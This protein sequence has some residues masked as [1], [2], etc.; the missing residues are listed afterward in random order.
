MCE[1]IYAM[2]LNITNSKV[3]GKIRLP[4]SKSH[5][6]R[7][8]FIASLSD[9]KCEILEP[10]VSDDALSAIKACNQFGAK[11]ST[12]ENKYIVNGFSGKPR[13]PQ[14]EVNVGNSG[15]TLRFAI[16]MASLVDG[17]CKI[18]GDE[19]TNKRQIYPLFSSLRDL[20]VSGMLHGHNGETAPIVITGPAKGGK[21]KI[22][23]V[24][25]QYLSSLL[26]HAPLFEKDTEI[27]VTRLNEVPYVEMT[28]WWLDK[29][30]IQYSN[31]DLKTFKIKGGQSYKAFNCTIPGDLSAATFFIVLAAISG[32]KITIEKFDIQDTQGDKLVLDIVEKMGAKVERNENEVTITGDKLNGMTVDMNSI[33]DA[34]PAMAV[35]GCFAKGETRLVNVP[36]ARLKETDRISVMCAELKKMG[37][38]IEE[39]E[40][41]LIIRPSKLKGCNVSGHSDHRVVMALAVAGLNAEGNTVIDSAEA[42]NITFP[43]FVENIVDCGAIAELQNGD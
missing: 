9:G 34:L 21:T 23:A 14:E 7:A 4:G 2:L 16:S 15:T 41:G 20:G 36:Q 37:A 1:G 6:I 32:E 43:K 24:T 18:L 12:Y 42:I 31:E 17:S 10:L 33:P 5:T 29:M 11:I 30:G 25:S 8:L 39:L 35:L 22:D 40:D 19:Q 28:L 27:E 3:S 26:I 13:Q 38:D